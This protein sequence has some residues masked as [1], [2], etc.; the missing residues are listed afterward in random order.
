VAFDVRE[1]MP[2][3]FDPADTSVELKPAVLTK[4]MK[5]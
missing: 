5:P 3:D 4:G 1:P 2:A